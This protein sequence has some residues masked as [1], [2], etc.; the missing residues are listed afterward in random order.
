MI[1]LAVVAAALLLAVPALVQRGQ[2]AAAAV[3]AVLGGLGVA[4]VVA[5]RVPTPP[6]PPDRLSP[7]A[8]AAAI[9]GPVA[10]PAAAYRPTP[11]PDRAV[12]VAVVGDSFV[13]GVGVRPEESLPRLLPERLAPAWGEVEVLDLGMPGFNAWNTARWIEHIALPMR[14][15]VVVWSFVLNDLGD[16][17]TPSADLVD[18]NA[19]KQPASA[20]ARLWA[21][22]PGA[23]WSTW[24]LERAY[25]RRFDPAHN[26]LFLRGFAADLEAHAAAARLGGARLVVLLWP[27]FHRLDA[28]PFSS[29]HA[30]VREV[31]AAAGAELLDLLPA[32]EGTDAAR[33]WAHPHDHHPNAAAHAVAADALAEHLL[34]PHLLAPHL[35]APHLLASPEGG[36]APRPDGAPTCT[37]RLPEDPASLAIAE[38]RRARC[39]APEAAAPS[40]AL[41]EAAV[42]ADPAELPK[43]PLAAAHAA[44]AM[45]QADMEGSP[46]VG[47]AAAR[48]LDA[49]PPP[50]DEPPVFPGV[51]AVVVQP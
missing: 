35:S 16:P 21:R 15:D 45:L 12:T 30:R 11:P 17:A 47:T 28:Y 7:I 4:E 46:E 23:R 18:P 39:L 51:E 9:V 42:A 38:A 24:Q 6:L 3:A 34:A 33:W 5:S 1:A 27:L 10:L 44:R 40:L 32:F 25:N 20:L 14:P 29:A 50:P 2:R 13:A 49:L 41:A 48:L 31:A 26:A 8:N 43:W 36:P 37:A 19:A 22:G